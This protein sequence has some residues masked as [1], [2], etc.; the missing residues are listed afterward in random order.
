MSAPRYA[1]AAAA[2]LARAAER[3]LPPPRPESRDSAIQA[4]EMAIR[5]RSR[6]RQR[7]RYAEALVA[8]ASVAAAT[9]L[10]AGFRPHRTPVTLSGSQKPSSD[11]AGN[12]GNSGKKAS[13][14]V[15]VVAHPMGAG[16]SIVAGEGATRLGDGV[17]LGEGSHVVAAADG[18]ALLSFS[19]GTKLT[20][21][22][23]GNLTI[24]NEAATELFTLSGGSLRADVAKLSAGQR[25]V[26]RTR[27]AEVEVRGTSFRVEV[28][29][30]DALCGT[31][32]R[33]TVFEGVVV[34]RAS[35][36]ET[37][38]AAGESWPRG[39]AS[40]VGATLPISTARGP[41]LAV[42]RRHSPTLDA[43]STLAAQNDAFARAVAAKRRG[44][45]DEALAGFDSFLSLY[46]GSALAESATV[47][48]MRLL[49]SRDRASASGAAKRYLAAYPAGF[50]RAEAELLAGSP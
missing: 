34:V 27:D 29:P 4:L 1:R 39:C 35:E 9:A 6:K 17:T 15:V 46:P 36:G 13:D 44:A 11:A 31:T 41:S 30:R 47:E 28:A 3:E 7:L 45:T 26:V 49:A 48:K 12:G 21:E 24:V 8:V 25:F 37:R 22:E 2:L 38:V 16:A 18:R 42:D 23:G 32:T 33:L 14:T 43:A 50:A 40:A 19:T 10:V 5:R 20:L